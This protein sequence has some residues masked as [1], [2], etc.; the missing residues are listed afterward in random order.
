MLIDGAED[1]YAGSILGDVALGP[2]QLEASG[3][4]LD[5]SPRGE[6]GRGLGRQNPT[7]L[8]V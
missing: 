8:K 6:V 4:C 2:F 3:A 5:T 1:E 7:R